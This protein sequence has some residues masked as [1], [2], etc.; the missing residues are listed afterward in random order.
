M[1]ATMATDRSAM[2]TLEYI[3][4]KK[5]LAPWI[6]EAVLAVAGR[7]SMS[8]VDF[9]DAC[10][11]TGAVAFHMRC[12]GAR[13][14]HVNDTEPYA[15]VLGHAVARSTATPRCLELIAE[16]NAES[17][18]ESDAELIAESD[19]AAQ[20]P[21]GL[22]EREYTEPRMFFTKE[23]ARK[24]D[25][26]RAAIA[27]AADMTDD[28]RAFVLASLIT[29][30]DAV[31]NTTSVYGAYLKKYKPAALRPFVL[32]PVHGLTAEAP[33]TSRAT[34][35]DALDPAT[36]A[37]AADPNGAQLVVYVDPPY[38]Q[39]QYSKNYFPLNAVA[40][41]PATDAEFK[42]N[43]ESVTG[44]PAGCY[45]SP[46]CRKAGAAGAFR[47]LLEAV[48]ATAHVVVSYSSEGIVARDEMVGILGDYG[49]VSVLEREHKRFASSACNDKGKKTTVE[50]LFCVRR[51]PRTEKA[52]AQ[53]LAEPV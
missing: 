27:T 20:A 12:A 45:L 48:P 33:P 34:R 39:R 43:D 35:T 51:P 40:G 1:T 15:A 50:Y 49:E 23:N 14:V 28:E 16:S 17:D 38:N 30:A 25:A 42:V 52:P 8:D 6:E 3:G 10:C 44:I 21:V 24:I 4:C 53:K 29:S 11:G 32:A 41:D 46:F 19:A 5:Q 36:Y 22:V 7:D 13:S 31:S 47:A 18:A 2:R 26:A 9:V 37:H